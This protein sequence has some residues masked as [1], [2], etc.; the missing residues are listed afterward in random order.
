MLGYRNMPRSSQGSWSLLNSSPHTPESRTEQQQ[1]PS[2]HRDG[3]RWEAPATPRGELA[4]RAAAWTQTTCHFCWCSCVARFSVQLNKV[5]DTKLGLGSCSALCCP[6]DQETG[7]K[8]LGFSFFT[9]WREEGKQF[10]PHLPPRCLQNKEVTNSEQ[11]GLS[12]VKRA[13]QTQVHR[14]HGSA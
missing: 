12:Q 3:D 13:L 6:N 8:S 11:K 10:L 2:N 9:N 7:F 4:T 14:L 5:T 1:T